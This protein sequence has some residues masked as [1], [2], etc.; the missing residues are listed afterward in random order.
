MRILGYILLGLILLQLTHMRNEIK[1][2][3]YQ[4]NEVICVA[5]EMEET[6]E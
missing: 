2:I 4:I 3:K 1:V 6:L 5:L